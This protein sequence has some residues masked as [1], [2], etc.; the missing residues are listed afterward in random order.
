M[1]ENFVLTK[2]KSHD[3]DKEGSVLKWLSIFGLVAL[4]ILPD[5]PRGIFDGFPVTHY[6][7]GLLIILIA[8]TAM[9]PKEFFKVQGKLLYSGLIFAIIFLVFLRIISWN[10]GSGGGLSACYRSLARPLPPGQCEFSTDQAL[11]RTHYT[12]T[13]TRFEFY[14]YQWRMGFLNTLRLNIYPWETGNVLRERLPF[15]VSWSGALLLPPDTRSLVFELV[16]EL[17]ILLEGRIN[18][19]KAYKEQPF[20][21]VWPLAKTHKGT[22]PIALHYRFDDGSRS[23]QPVPPNGPAFFRLLLQNFEGRSSVYDTKT[24]ISFHKDFLISTLSYSGSVLCF[25]FLFIVIGLSWIRFAK[26]LHKNILLVSF[27]LLL[28]AFIPLL[29]QGLSRPLFPLEHILFSLF[30]AWVIFVVALRYQGMKIPL[31]FI[32][33]SV[34][35]LIFFNANWG[36]A[37]FNDLPVMFAGQDW[38]TY[39]SWAFEILNELS[40]RGGESIFYYQPLYR[41]WLAGLHIIFG[42]S[43]IPLRIV[44]LTVLTTLSL[45]IVC[46]SVTSF[47]NKSFLYTGLPVGLLLGALIIEFTFWGVTYRSLSESLYIILI[48]GAIMA[49]LYTKN[50]IA[51]ALLCSLSAITRLNMF[52]ATVALFIVITIFECR[53]SLREAGIASLVC[54]LILCL[55][56]LHNWN[57]GGS[58]VFIPQSWKHDSNLIIKIGSYLNWPW[59]AQV[60]AHLDI[61]S[62]NL[63]GIGLSYPD[64]PHMPGR[65]GVLQFC[66]FLVFVV[67]TVLAI[68]LAAIKKNWRLPIIVLP[69]LLAWAPFLMF[70][71]DNYYPRL[72]TPGNIIVVYCFLQLVKEINLVYNMPEE[73]L[74]K[75]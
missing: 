34:A 11:E 15:E 13:D 16:G 70:K 45:A 71:S 21:I 3:P 67:S 32:F 8:G 58:A 52:P 5:V 74:I 7:E 75:T 57:Y 49:G 40:L 23:M 68:I 22:I 14:R 35:L 66:S 37:R 48:L 1:L 54:I 24:L 10:Y 47:S 6:F 42:D 59:S 4:L 20:K 44:E 63:T 64:M 41:Y 46:K 53:F 27:G 39:E 30:V 65:I 56:I 60:K 2:S 36:S 17:R 19:F 50:I 62:R 31:P 12:R 26:S 33:M 69:G 38:L 73:L 25:L 43:L 9:L 29:T 51:V 72:V 55:P 18:T 28:C 61:T